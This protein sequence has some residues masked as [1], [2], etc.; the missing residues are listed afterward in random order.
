MR[1]VQRH[2]RIDRIGSKHREVFLRCVFPDERLDEL[3]RLE[4][5]LNNKLAQAAASVGVGEVIPDQ[6]HQQ[7]LNFTDTRTEIEQLHAED[8]TIFVRGGTELDAQSGEEFRAELRYSLQ[9]PDTS[10]TVKGLPWGT[11]SGM[12]GVAGMSGYVFCARVGDDPKPRFR[13]VSQSGAITD[14][15][16]ECLWQARPPEGFDTSRVLDDDTATA[17]FDAWTI[18]QDDIVTGWNFYADKANLEPRIPKALRD[19]AEVLRSNPPAGLTDERIGAAVRAL[20]S[21]YTQRITNLVREALR[22]A[23]TPSTQA[24]EVLRVI[25]EQGLVPQ[26]PVIPLP[27]ITSDDVHLVCWQALT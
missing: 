9:D 6:K 14:D 7:E 16:L 26:P 13:F 17:A 18:A 11:G 10:R 21:P 27:A 12:A 24:E 22:N 2:G 20:Q 15:T 3:L 8:A 25:E 1:L 23:E 4:D 19:A 5:R